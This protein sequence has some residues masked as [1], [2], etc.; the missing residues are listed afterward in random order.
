MAVRLRQI[1]S[2]GVQCCSADRQHIGA[3]TQRAT[4]IG[5]C[6]LRRG[7]KP[8]RRAFLDLHLWRVVRLR[9]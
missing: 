3:W 9:S 6:A 2:V 4:C 8:G 5:M 7:R 1:E